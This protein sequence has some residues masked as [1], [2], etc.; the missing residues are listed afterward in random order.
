MGNEN[1]SL[2]WLKNLCRIFFLIKPLDYKAKIGT[3]V[4]AANKTNLKLIC[5]DSDAADWEA[6]VGMDP[7]ETLLEPLLEM[8]AS[9]F[10]PSDGWTSDV[11]SSRFWKYDVV[12][13][14]AKDESTS[15]LIMIWYLMCIE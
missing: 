9:K 5:L 7:L 4:I 2:L 10:S 3:S 11:T 6:E 8:T 1:I 14:A 15:K 12:V 13:G